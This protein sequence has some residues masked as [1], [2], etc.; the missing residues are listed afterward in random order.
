[1]LKIIQLRRSWT[2][3]IE[4]FSEIKY[5]HFQCSLHLENSQ[6]FVCVNSVKPF[7]WAYIRIND[8]L[9]I[10]DIVTGNGE[11][12]YC[13]MRRSRM[14]ARIN[15]FFYSWIILRQMHFT[16]LSLCRVSRTRVHWIR[17]CS[18]TTWIGFSLFCILC[19][20]ND[21]GNSEQVGPPW[22]AV[23]KTCVSQ[24]V[25]ASSDK[26]CRRHLHTGHR[27]HLHH[28]W[29]IQEL[30]RWEIDPSSSYFHWRRVWTWS[31]SWKWRFQPSRLFS[32]G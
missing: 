9:F 30:A 8:V 5:S 2:Q 6:I 4:F 16:I 10:L 31:L 27:H 19:N 22:I 29:Q 3:E 20:S 12:M 7:I 14:F 32:V 17:F 26:N 13:W 1:M 15:I 21:R 18:R 11:S 28:H 24:L 23:Y 25:L